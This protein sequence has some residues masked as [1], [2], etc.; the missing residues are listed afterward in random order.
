M[1]M[2]QMMSKLD[3]IIV[4]SGD[5]D[6]EDAVRYLKANGT[7]VEAAAFGRSTSGKLKDAVDDFVDLDENPKRFLMPIRR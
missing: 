4:V 6:Y 3:V 7:R 1:D 5:G 2:V